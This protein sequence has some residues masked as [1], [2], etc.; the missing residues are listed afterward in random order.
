M[1]RHGDAI[2]VMWEMPMH[3]GLLLNLPVRVLKTGLKHACRQDSLLASI[4]T[5]YTQ[6]TMLMGGGTFRFL[7]RRQTLDG[8]IQRESERYIGGFHS[9]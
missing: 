8:A 6:L 9:E 3:H 1:G 7:D 4:N 5:G 2:R